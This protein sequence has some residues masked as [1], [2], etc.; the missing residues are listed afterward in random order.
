MPKSPSFLESGC[1]PANTVPVRDDFRERTRQ[2][3]CRRAGNRCSLCRTVTSGP[4]TD[5]EKAVNLGVAAHITAAAAG[6]PRYDPLLSP[7]QRS[8]IDNGIW[9]CCNCAKLI[10]SDVTLYSVDFLRRTKGEAERESARQVGRSGRFG[11]WGAALAERLFRRAVRNGEASPAPR[12]SGFLG[13]GARLILSF[14]SFLSSVTLL[15]YVGARYRAGALAMLPSVVRRDF[16]AG[17]DFAELGRMGKWAFLGPVDFMR[18][19]DP[20]GAIHGVWL[21]APLF[22]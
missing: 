5:P 6:G 18:L 2:T 4:H 10:D 8:H 14:L 17:F 21:R 9:L 7:E 12:Y 19:V 20:S 3:L 1:M 15:L 13:I 11:S 16:S 22:C